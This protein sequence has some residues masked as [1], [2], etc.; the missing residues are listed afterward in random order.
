M[1][2]ACPVAASG[3][4]SHISHSNHVFKGA[5]ICKGPGRQN[6]RHIRIHL[7]E[8]VIFIYTCPGVPA[9][10][11]ALLLLAV[12]GNDGD[13]DGRDDRRDGASTSLMHA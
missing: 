5:V 7:T 9:I 2:V 6:G 11:A 3:R 12:C 8:A 13:N 1:P 10:F 4:I